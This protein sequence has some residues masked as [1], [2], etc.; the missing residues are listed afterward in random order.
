MHLVRLENCVCPTYCQW[1]KMIDLHR[2]YQQT[3]YQYTLF[4]WFVCILLCRQ[5]L[6]CVLVIWKYST[7]VSV[8]FCSDSRWHSLPAKSPHVFSVPLVLPSAP[9]VVLARQ[10]D[11]SLHAGHA[12]HRYQPQSRAPHRH[13]PQRHACQC[14]H[15]NQRSS[16]HCLS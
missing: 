9:S 4:C 11:P 15:P 5:H 12:P 13:I 8:A 14:A 16:E 6:T 10:S 7:V 3:Q 1:S 2:W